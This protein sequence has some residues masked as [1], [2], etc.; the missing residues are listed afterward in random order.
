LT[1]KEPS[2]W[3]GAVLQSILS[4][5]PKI[6]CSLCHNPSKSWADGFRASGIELWTRLAV[7]PWPALGAFKALIGEQGI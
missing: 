5:S 4:G 3:Q 2:G 6:S 1:L 7:I